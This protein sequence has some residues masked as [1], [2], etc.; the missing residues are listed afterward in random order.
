MKNF[1]LGLTIVA[2]LGVAF[3]SLAQPAGDAK[4]PAPPASLTEVAPIDVDR[5]ADACDAT[6]KPEDRAVPL[7]TSCLRECRQDLADCREDGNSVAVCRA[8][9]AACRAA[10]G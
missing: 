7:S 8:R 1:A 5:A 2:L 4:T 9:L 3:N 6:L 10:C